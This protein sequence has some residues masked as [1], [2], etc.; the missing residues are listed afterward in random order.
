MRTPCPAAPFGINHVLAGP[1][2][3]ASE[4]AK[5]L[6]AWKAVV[7]PELATSEMTI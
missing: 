4:Q 6:E 2:W 1:E 3:S 5:K 7:V